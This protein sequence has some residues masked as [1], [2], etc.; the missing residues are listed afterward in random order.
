MPDFC[1]LFFVRLWVWNSIGV[2]M[3]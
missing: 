1:L 3:S 2:R